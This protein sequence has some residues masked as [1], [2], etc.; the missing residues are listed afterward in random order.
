MLEL[1]EDG[2]E[3]KNS[4]PT[5]FPKMQEKG[6]RRTFAASVPDSIR[7]C[8]QPCIALQKICVPLSSVVIRG[9]SVAPRC[10]YAVVRGF[11]ATGVD[12]CQYSF[13]YRCQCA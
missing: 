2:V 13:R 10:G 6:R 3:S 1:R 8:V 5:A 4:A 7:P 9:G 11:I 12:Q